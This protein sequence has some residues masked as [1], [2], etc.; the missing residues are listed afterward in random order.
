[1][2]LYGRYDVIWF[3]D[4]YAVV[5]LKDNHRI[6]YETN[7]RQKAHDKAAKLEKEQLNE[8]TKTDHN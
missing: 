2:G 3:P 8:K 4:G 6:V 5:D 7:N 1:M